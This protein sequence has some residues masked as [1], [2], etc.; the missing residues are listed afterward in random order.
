[1]AQFQTAFKRV[2]GKDN[3]A[4]Y[5]KNI[6]HPFGCSCCEITFSVHDRKSRKRRPF[7]MSLRVQSSYERAL[8]SIGRA[9]SLI[10]DEENKG[11]HFDTNS[12]EQRLKE[13]AEGDLLEWAQR[14]ST[15]MLSAVN[16]DNLR[17]W[18]LHSKGMGR[19]LKDEL[20]NA[21]VGD[22]FMR[23]QQEQ[24]ELI[25][26]LPKEAA[27]RIQELARG[28]LYT[29]ERSTSLVDEIMKTGDIT[30]R[31]AVMVARTESARA[32]SLFTQVRAHQIGCLQFI[33]RCVRDGR[34]RPSHREMD[35]L[36]C[37]YAKPPLV[38]GQSLLPGQ[39]YNCRCWQEPVLRRTYD[40]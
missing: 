19:A 22:V 5:S 13:Y 9:V 14:I 30:R 28:L 38:D 2:L 33:W 12:A 10:L 25:T 39:I 32:S 36:V 24:V 20:E 16:S 17:E 27:K 21:S 4:L 31:H 15:T 40:R 23:L 8:K 3:A 37:N 1:M 18:K 35:G 6:Q 11:D 29:G 7:E 26:S 34:T